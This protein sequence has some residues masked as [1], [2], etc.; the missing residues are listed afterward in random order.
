MAPMGQGV[1][2]SQYAERPNRKAPL[3]AQAHHTKIE[4]KMSVMTLSVKECQHTIRSWGQGMNQI[5]HIILR[6]R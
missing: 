1:P 6:R 3:Y 4:A 2:L 5:H